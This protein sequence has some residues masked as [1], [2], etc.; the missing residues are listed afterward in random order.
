METAEFNIT[1]LDE[2]ENITVTVCFSAIV[3]EVLN[4]D[5]V[6]EFVDTSNESVAIASLYSDFIYGFS[7]RLLTVPRNFTGLFQRC[8]DFIVLGDD[9]IEFDEVIAL[10]V[11]PLNGIDSV[12]YPLN[13]ESL[14]INIFDNDGQKIRLHAMQGLK[15]SWGGGGGQPLKLGI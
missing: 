8:L 15:R 7:P 14:R 5:A 2:G 10:V 11:Q 4:R 9:L 13:S 12:V 6:F 3:S 1:E